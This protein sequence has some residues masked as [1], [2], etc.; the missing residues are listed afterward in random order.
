MLIAVP[1]ISQGQRRQKAKSLRLTKTELLPTGRYTV[2]IVIPND[3]FYI[4]RYWTVDVGEINSAEISTVGWVA[5]G[6]VAV[7][8]AAAAITAVIVVKKR[9]KAGIV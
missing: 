6:A 1:Q 8:M 4:D 9:K 7:L 3:N 2:W 5:I